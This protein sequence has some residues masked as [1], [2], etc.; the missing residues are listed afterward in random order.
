[1]KTPINLRVTIAQTSWFQRGVAMLAALLALAAVGIGLAHVLNQRRTLAP[2]AASLVAPASAAQ[3]RF[4]ALKAQQLDQFDAHEESGSVRAR[5]VAYARFLA[6][7][8]RQLDQFDA[9][10]R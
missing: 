1:M 6:L 2:V 4:A 7:K 10:S 5:L 9:H 8:A 3:E